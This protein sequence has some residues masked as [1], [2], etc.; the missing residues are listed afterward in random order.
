MGKR[1][2]L[3]L[4]VDI[5]IAYRGQGPIKKWVKIPIVERLEPVTGTVLLTRWPQIELTHL[6]LESSRCKRYEDGR[7][8]FVSSLLEAACK[9]LYHSIAKR[10]EKTVSREAS[11]QLQQ[12][13]PGQIVG[14]SLVRWARQV[15]L[16]EH[17]KRLVQGADFDLSRGKPPV[18]RDDSLSFSISVSRSWLGRDGPDMIDI[19]RTS[20]AVDLGLSVALINRVLSSIF[21]RDWRPVLSRNSRA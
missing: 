1:L 12:I 21:D 8:G 9:Q 18:S 6:R 20:A 17:I 15:G 14:Q 5:D 13:D 16:A 10:I 7:L 4:S 2:E 19:K 11:R 3:R